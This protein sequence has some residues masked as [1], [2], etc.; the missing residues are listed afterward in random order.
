MMNYLQG[1]LKNLFNPAV[2]LLAV[3][4]CRSVISSKAK[5]YRFTKLVNSTLGKYSYMGNGSWAINADIGSFCSIADQVNIGLASHSLSYLSTSPLFTQKKNGTGISW[6]EKNDYTSRRR[7]VIGHDVWIGSR[8]LIRDGVV[9]GNGAV[10]GAGAV[11]TKNVPPYAI[12]GGVPAKVIRYR[13]SSEII[14][15]LEELQWWNMDEQQLK[16][17][18]YLYQHSTEEK[19]IEVLLKVKRRGVKLLNSRSCPSFEERRVA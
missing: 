14:V 3:V 6:T 7:V 12:V 8:V 19:D 11:V 16:E 17:Y 15:R 18:T 13:F 1:K 5:M 2:T 9:V 10:I 4:D